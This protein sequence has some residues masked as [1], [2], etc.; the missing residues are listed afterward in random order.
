M[1]DRGRNTSYHRIEANER[2]RVH[3]GD[4]IYYNYY[5]NTETFSS[6]RNPRL[7][8]PPRQPNNSQVVS[9]FVPF[10]NEIDDIANVSSPSQSSDTASASYSDFGRMNE[11]YPPRSRTRVT[12]YQVIEYP[13]ADDSRYWYFLPDVELAEDIVMKSKVELAGAGAEIYRT[14]RGGRSGYEI[15]GELPREEQLARLRRQSKK[16][17]SERKWEKDVM[18]ND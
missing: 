17:R 15:H 3:N 16:Y 14:T 10:E 4:V 1:G 6:T 18:S 12:S 5:I 8:E 11:Q 9:N 7:Q 2:S 13:T